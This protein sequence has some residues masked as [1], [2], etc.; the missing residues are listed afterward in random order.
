MKACENHDG[1]I[2]VFSGDACPLC[3]MEKK[4]KNIGEE[5][6]KSMI[7]MKQIQTT[8]EEAGSRPA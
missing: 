8:A 7:I 4:L 5:I 6:E 3:N 1:S 2:V